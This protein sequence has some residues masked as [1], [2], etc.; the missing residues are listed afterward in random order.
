MPRRG[1]RR[2]VCPL[3]CSLD[4]LGDRW[5]IL[6]LRDLFAGRSR[7]GE[8]AAS[9]ER[10]ATNILADR[11]ERLRRHGLVVAEESPERAGAAVYALTTK[12]RELRPVLE[13][14]RDWGLRHI[15]GTRARIAIPDEGGS[16]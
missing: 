10:I 2:S 16:A 11:L 15:R 1:S 5:T 13:A 6:V 7:Y 9:P 8:F 3:A 12:G 14:L 4:I